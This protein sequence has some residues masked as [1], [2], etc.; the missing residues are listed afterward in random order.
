MSLFLGI[1]VGTYETKG[2]LTDAAGSI[3]ATAAH[4]H[5]MLVPR[6][7]WAEHRPE[8]DWW[9]G[10]VAVSRA[11][12]ADSGTAPGEVAAI[13]VSAIGPCMVPVDRD[14]R[15]LTNAVLYGVDTRAADEVANLTQRLGEATLLA[16][17]GN[18][19]TSQS[20]GPKILW[21]ARHR[22][23]VFA[24]AD[25]IGTS[26]TWLVE[27]LTGARVIDHYTAAGFTPL[28]DIGAQDWAADLA[29]GIID[30]A[31]LPRLLWSG[32]VAGH[33]T[34]A[35]AA[36]L[37]LAAGT[38][39]TTG[40][41]DAAA[42]ALSVGVRHPGDMMLMYGSTI[43]VIALARAAVRDGRLWS[44]PW[45]FPG[46]HAV[47]AGQ[48]TS[49]TLTHW[50]RDRFARELPADEAFAALAREAES[51]PPGADGLLCL[52]YFSGERTPIHDPLARGTFFGLNLTHGRGH[53][54][55]ALLEGI[56]FGTCHIVEA[57]AGAGEPPRRI[58]A[59]GGGT[60]NPVWLQA[61]SD[62]SGLDQI[63]PRTTLGACYG[64]AFLAAL[65]TGAVE[66][67]DIERWN[68]PADRVAA[69]PS[70]VYRRQYALWQRLYTQTRD[71]AH[72]LAADGA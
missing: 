48:A 66:R 32:E 36:E 10:L 25:G 19:L 44:A 16:R 51:V 39:V 46:E 45:L 58:L 2:V 55:R 11:V 61:T 56:A 67:T 5:E 65:A 18:L 28:Y 42:E 4:G 52:P 60:R 14:G 71:I 38:Q 59:V 43:F 40:T 1:D 68:P 57:F 8:A 62:I 13:A 41:I 34:D 54:V 21:L 22:P 64:D 53:L 3:V 23:E 31:R 33:L 29:D 70:G 72:A 63:L 49:G 12:M 35:A 24:A 27:R 7:G 20:V 26:T 69:R 15:A 30:V 37:G 50:F 6:A 17:C 47:M 9:A